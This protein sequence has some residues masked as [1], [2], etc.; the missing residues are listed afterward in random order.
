MGLHRKS[1]RKAGDRMMKKGIITTIRTLKLTY[2]ERYMIDQLGI[3]TPNH[4]SYLIN[5]GNLPRWVGK[6]DE[7]Q[8][9]GAGLWRRIKNDEM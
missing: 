1:K 2:T 7:I 8:Y 4:K 3:V 6:D 9:L 5:D